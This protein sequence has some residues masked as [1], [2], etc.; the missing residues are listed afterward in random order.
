MGAPMS[1]VQGV[2]RDPTQ[3][4]VGGCP[5]GGGVVMMRSGRK[6]REHTSGGGSGLGD[7][8]AP[9]LPD[10]AAQ[11]QALGSLLPVS[12]CPGAPSHPFLPILQG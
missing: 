1:L 7:T 11:G 9:P 12:L 6:E 2:L 8:M 4:R 3:H 10:R 5:F